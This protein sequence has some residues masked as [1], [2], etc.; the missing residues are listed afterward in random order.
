MVEQRTEN[1]C[2]AG[3]IPALATISILSFISPK[4]TIFTVLFP[5]I[6]PRTV[7][8][9]VF[10]SLTKFLAFIPRGL[11]RG[12]K[13]SRTQRGYKGGIWNNP[14]IHN[15]NSVSA[16]RNEIGEMSRCSAAWDSQFQRISLLFEALTPPKSDMLS[17]KVQKTRRLNFNYLFFFRR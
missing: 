10:L 5:K 15:G 13:A 12:M 7:K 17:I 6:Y 14:L 2:V 9:R 4:N 11:P 8:I 3:S 16:E 1:P